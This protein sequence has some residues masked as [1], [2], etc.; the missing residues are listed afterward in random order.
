M[1]FPE[2]AVALY[3][4]HDLADHCWSSARA[5]A[6]HPG[7]AESVR[8]SRDFQVP[9]DRRLAHGKRL[10][11]FVDRRLAPCQ[12]NQDP[13]SRGVRQGGKGSVQSFSI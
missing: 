9:R 6:E 12:P 5:C 13:P 10:R 7:R 4:G 11:E 1:S 3:P 8:P 2:L